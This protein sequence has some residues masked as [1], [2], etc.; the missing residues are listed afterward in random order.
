MN[1][2]GAKKGSCLLAFM[3]TVNQDKTSSNIQYK[4][5]CVDK[6]TKMGIGSAVKPKGLWPAQIVKLSTGKVYLPNKM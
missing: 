4:N 5:L 2:W 1:K 6:G 3:L